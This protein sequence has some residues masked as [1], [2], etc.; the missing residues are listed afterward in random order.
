MKFTALASSSA[1]NCYLLDDG[2]TKILLECGVS[3]D[4]I[5]LGTGFR[6]AEVAGCLV[7][8]EHGDHSQAAKHLLHSGIDIYASS[9]TFW[10]LGLHEDHHH[11]LHTIRALEQFTIGTWTVMPFEA[12]HDAV[13]PLGFVLAS[14]S[15]KALY[16]TDSGECRFR[17]EGLTH[18]FL[19]ANHDAQIVAER[20]AAGEIHEHVARRLESNHMEIGR[21]V[22]FLSAL[23]LRAVREIHLLHLSDT[24]ANER[25]FK[26]AVARATGKPV[27]VAARR[28][29]VAMR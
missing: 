15:E 18:L 10:A 3:A 24:N 17:F 11:R 21:L 20:L 13:E 29:E 12:Q 27:Y 25:Q 8:H 4:A 14:G 19:E 7:S 28:R 2:V 26:D 16:L 9:G 6:L 23:D 1:G 22:R 5:R